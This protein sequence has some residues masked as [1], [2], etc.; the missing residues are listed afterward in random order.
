MSLNYPYRSVFPETLRKYPIVSNILRQVTK[1]YKVPDTD[2]TLQKGTMMIIPVYAIQ[3]DP[4]YFPDPD[5]FDPNRFS[6][7]EVEKR[8]NLP[9]TPFIPFGEG[10]KE[11]FNFLLGS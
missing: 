6:P 10:K 2:I 3:R 5:K 9:F 11:N 1:D 4:E 7:E 8:T